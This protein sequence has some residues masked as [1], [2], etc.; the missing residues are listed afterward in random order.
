[1]DH[2]SVVHVEMLDV[3]ENFENYF[4]LYKPFV[5]LSLLSAPILYENVISN[6]K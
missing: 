6:K 2:Q 1:M 4:K 3:A 5:Y